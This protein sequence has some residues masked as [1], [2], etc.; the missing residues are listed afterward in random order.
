M[1]NTAP[2]TTLDS[3]P[4]PPNKLTPPIA[5]AAIDSIP[6]DVHEIVWSRGP[7]YMDLAEVVTDV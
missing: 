5:Q 2:N 1:I 4:T 7:T 6:M 3:R